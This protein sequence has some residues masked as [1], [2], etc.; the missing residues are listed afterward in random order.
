MGQEDLPEEAEMAP[1]LVQLL[2]EFPVV[3]F[4]VVEAPVHPE[5]PEAPV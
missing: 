3:E 4:P 5:V 2:V 1:L